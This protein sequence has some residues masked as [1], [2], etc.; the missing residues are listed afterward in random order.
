MLL[1]SSR[2]ASIAR[3]LTWK[4]L[5]TK[6]GHLYFQ[7]AVSRPRKNASAVLLWPTPRSN[8]RGDYQYSGGDH[9]KPILTLS[10]A[11]KLFPTPSASDCKRSGGAS[12]MRRHSPCL[13]AY[14]KMFAT[15]QAR[16]YRTGRR[17]RFEDPSKTRNLNDQ[18]GGQLNP[19]WVEWLMGFPLGWTD[20]DA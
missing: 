5:T 4:P 13:P 12:D 15:P 8:E 9:S 1:A 10:G 19:T 6:L 7:L 18:I 3:Y 14:V 2:W 11:V 20:L 16:D 17:D